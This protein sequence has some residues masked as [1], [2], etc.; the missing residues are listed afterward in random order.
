M[1]VTVLPEPASSSATG[2]DHDDFALVVS[3]IAIGA[4]TARVPN[5]P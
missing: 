4:L 2:V 3:G 5:L 1:A